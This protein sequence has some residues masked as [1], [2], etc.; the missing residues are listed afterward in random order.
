MKIASV[1]VKN[2]RSLRDVSI[3]F[4]DV[5][6]LI[7][8]NGTGKSTVLR[9]L[10]WYFNGSRGGDLTERDCSHGYADEE[11]SVEVTFNDLTD[12]DRAELGKYAPAG[13]DSFTAWK[14]RNPATGEEYLSANAKGYAPFATIRSAARVQEKKDLYSALRTTEGTL[15]LPAATTGQQ[16]ETAMSAWESEHL[17]QLTD[18]PESLQT[19]F[20]G[21]NSAGKMSGLFDFVLVTADLR[22]NEESL[23]NRSTIIGRILERAVDRTAADEE[24]ARVVEQSRQAQQA[25]Y[26]DKFNDQ[27]VEITKK[28][29]DVVQSYTPGRSLKVSPSEMDL[30]APKT[31][32]NVSIMDGDDETSV[33]R[34]GHGFQR[35]LLISALQLLAQTGA[36]GDDGVICLAIEEPELFQHPIQAQAFA[37]VL[38][39]LAEDEE[40][41]IQVTYATHSPYFLEASKFAQVRRLVRGHDDRSEVSAHFSSLDDVK[42]AL[43]GHVKSQTVDRQLDGTI[44]NSLPI[45]LF[46]NRVL[47]VEGTTECAIIHGIADRQRVGAL[48]AAGVSVVEVSG[49]S[50]LPLAHAILTSLGIPTY[51]LFD[52]DAGFEERANAKNRPQEKIDEERR[53]H[54]SA[55]RTLLKYFGL[56]EEDFPQETEASDVTVLRDNLETLLAEQ[57]PEWEIACKELEAEAEVTLAKN[58]SAYR[59]ATLR[60]GGTPLALLE[61]VIERAR[62][63]TR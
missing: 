23:D 37:K 1:T 63:I 5:T 27:L 36:A 47:L 53:G 30:K 40:Q 45:A 29:N 43:T 14:L 6:T 57:W 22:A 48:E 54:V 50:N 34:Q 20:F 18:M 49:K 10:D 35:T 15:G 4:D 59:Q 12:S 28:L 11:I 17:D 52:G 44:S 26:A 62:G 32:F 9:A 38:R 7:G 42:A 51:C 60:S 31:T 46:A 21:F 41:G 16:I 58:Q 8:P 13:V 33:D 19:D 24:I 55:N 2:F 56:G 39:S 3:R 61:R 25:I